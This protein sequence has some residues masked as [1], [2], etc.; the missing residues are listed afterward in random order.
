MERYC[1]TFEIYGSKEE[2][3]KNLSWEEAIVEYNNKKKET[4]N[5]TRHSTCGKEINH[6]DKRFNL[7][8]EGSLVLEPM[9]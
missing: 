1:V 2:T 5:W 3:I 4:V 7:F 6:M 9:K 8:N